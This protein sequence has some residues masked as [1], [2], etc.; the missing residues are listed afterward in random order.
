M[1][2]NQTNK[3]TFP[4]DSPVVAA[5]PV[6]KMN[7]IIDKPAI[8]VYHLSLFHDLPLIL[9]KPRFWL[10][11]YIYISLYISL[12]I[13]RNQHFWMVKRNKNHEIQTLVHLSTPSSGRSPLL[14]RALQDWDKPWTSQ[15]SPGTIPTE[16]GKRRKTIWPLKT[17]LSHRIH[18]WYIC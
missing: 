16:P 9:H 14:Q 10:E 4:M 11:V 3:H 8:K 1:F 15:G 18:V 13:S 12:Y 2:T 7:Q 5:F 17:L 6:G